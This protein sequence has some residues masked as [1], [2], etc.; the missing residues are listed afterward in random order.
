[1]QTNQ[2]E[3][4]VLYNADE[5]IQAEMYFADF[6]LLLAGQGTLPEFAA[7]STKAAYCVLGNGLKLKGVVFFLFDVNENGE[8]DP[9]FNLPLQYLVK[10]A[11]IGCDLGD[12][13]IRKASRGQCPVP[14]H[15]INLWEPESSESS[16]EGADNNRAML[17]LQK[18]IFRNR[19]KVK[20][21]LYDGEDTFF[22]VDDSQLDEL[23]DANGEGAYTLLEAI[24]QA[25]APAPTHTDL[26]PSVPDTPADF[27]AKL[28]EVFGEAG[29]L[30]LQ[31]LIRLHTEQLEQARLKYRQDIDQ[32]QLAY[33][34]QMRSAREE[35]HGLK[36]A[37]RQEQS[38][39]RRL[40]EMLRG[41]I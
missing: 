33:L 18:R 27:S 1:M 29:R 32:Q 6:E 34:D 23:T 22:N 20:A 39:N 40:Q 36:V 38:R 16:K 3:L 5:E 7:S 13:G 8:L 21:L 26:Q 17:T 9:D 2:R 24:K 14:W 41:D 28:N 35:I 37:L 11:G 31:D 15:S 25:P 4:V 30:S 12:G 10:Q 19:L